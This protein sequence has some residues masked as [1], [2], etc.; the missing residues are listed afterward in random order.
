M[1]I[2]HTD[3]VRDAIKEMCIEANLVLSGDVERRICEARK[4]EDRKST[5]LNSSH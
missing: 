5:R 1:R 3:I 4:Q 2:V